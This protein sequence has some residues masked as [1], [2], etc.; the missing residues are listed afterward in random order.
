MSSARKV[1]A[2]PMFLSPYRISREK[3][4]AAALGLHT[5]S[6]DMMDMY[7]IWERFSGQIV[8][9][10]QRRELNYFVVQSALEKHPYTLG[11]MHGLRDICPAVLGIRVLRYYQGP[12]EVLERLLGWDDRFLEPIRASLTNIW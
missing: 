9:R 6:E 11:L 5:I 8:K 12:G 10:S 3:L 2:T 7:W 1:K 4:C